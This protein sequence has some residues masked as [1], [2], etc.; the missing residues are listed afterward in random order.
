MY[1]F[2]R[3]VLYISLTVSILL[4]TGKLAKAQSDLSREFSRIDSFLQVQVATQNIP[5][6]A[7]AV[8]RGDRIVYTKAFG[9]TNIS[10]GK[11][12]KPF[13]N[14]H[15]A[16]ISK[17]FAATAVMQLAQNGKIDIDRTLTAYI[18]YFRMKDDR[19]R[20]I[21]IKQFLNHT[22]GMP[23]VEDYEWEKNVIDEGAAERFTK[24]LA[25]LELIS[26]PGKEFHY[27]NIGFD[28]M[29]DLV[30]KVSGKTFE[31]YVKDNILVPLDMKNSSFFYPE[32]DSSIRTSPHIGNPSKVSPVYPYN[33]LHAPSS[34]LNTSAEELAHWM[35]VN[36]ND[37]QYNG[38][39]IL[40]PVTLKQ[41]MTPTFLSNKDR[42]VSI[43]L[44][45]FSYSYRG[46]TNLE[47]GGSDLGY[48]TMLSL[49]PDE[50][51]G[52]LILCNHNDVKIYDMRNW[53]RDILLDAM[54]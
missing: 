13:H 28:I 40:Q 39:S 32:T 35:I 48:R 17:T 9:V 18:P 52:I 36:L 42:N 4:N 2:I 27:S 3:P 45:W 8:T 33:R 26:E 20:N 31:A 24:S 29:A 10:T 43:G 23:D 22:S 6:I 50:K 37:G 5:G 53:I 19:F 34:T 47:H 30:A 41:M 14:F 15:V 1:N 11:T 12:L 44:S 38:K 46:S 51:L 21:T 7:I 16:S 49:I 25:E 54:K